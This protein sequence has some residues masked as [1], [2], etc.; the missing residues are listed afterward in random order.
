MSGH[1][2]ACLMRIDLIKSFDYVDWEYLRMILIKITF[3]SQI[4]EWIMACTLN[5]VFISNRLPSNFFKASWVIRKGCA[6]S[7]LLFLLFIHSLSRRFLNAFSSGLISRWKLSPKILLTHLMF[8][9]YVLVMG[10][11]SL[12]EWK[13]L[14][15][16]LN[17]FGVTIGLI[18]NKIKSTLISCDSE[19]Q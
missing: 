1:I 10:K 5:F 8:V 9:D 7:P 14:F 17:S 11:V 6:L 19:D 16:I 2:D 18:M 4:V 15:D 3:G 13:V 12:S